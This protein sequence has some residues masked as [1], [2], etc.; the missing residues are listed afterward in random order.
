[1]TRGNAYAVG[2]MWVATFAMLG[3]EY[4]TVE[5][6]GWLYFFRQF[7]TMLFCESVRFIDLRGTP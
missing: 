6:N 2:N 4:L 5:F 7:V 3:I 1:L